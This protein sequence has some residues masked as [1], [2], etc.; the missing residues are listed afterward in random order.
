[1][2]VYDGMTLTHFL[3]PLLCPFLLSRAQEGYTTC[4]K[5]DACIFSMEVCTG[6]ENNKYT[7]VCLDP[8]KHRLTPSLV[9]SGVPLSLYS[10]LSVR[11]M[12]TRLE[13]EDV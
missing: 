5:N 10:T 7:F 6:T 4:I 9:L 2:S 11:V 1:M 13:R 8:K 12:G 3:C